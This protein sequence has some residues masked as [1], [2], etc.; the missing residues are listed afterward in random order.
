MICKWYISRFVGILKV[1]DK[2]N[3]LSLLRRYY[4]F[5]SVTFN[6]RSDNFIIFL[7]LNSKKI[8]KFKKFIEM[9]FDEKVRQRKKM[10]G[11]CYMIS[12][13]II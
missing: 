7:R 3:L 8:I 2:K 12:R 6:E 13:I 10:L 11:Y 5:L 1:I 4:I 9:D